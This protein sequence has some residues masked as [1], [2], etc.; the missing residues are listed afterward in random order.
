M[1][2][3]SWLSTPVRL[4]E[5]IKSAV[6]AAGGLSAPDPAASAG[7][8]SAPAASFVNPSSV[9]LQQALLSQ[10]FV[11]AAD[12]IAQL[13]LTL[14]ADRITALDTAFSSGSVL[15]QRFFRQP[16]NSWLAGKHPLNLSDARWMKSAHRSERRAIGSASLRGWSGSTPP[17][18]AL[19]PA[20]AVAPPLVPR[21]GAGEVGFPPSRY[22]QPQVQ[23]VLWNAR[24]IGGS[25]RRWNQVIDSSSSRPMVLRA[26]PLR[27]QPP[28][29]T[30]KRPSTR[31]V[32]CPHLQ[33]IYCYYDRP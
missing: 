22:S 33:S 15:Y 1:Q 4:V 13:D 14:R 23:L 12:T 29:T 5:V 31:V 11:D 32:V 19:P 7:S 17:A 3:S 30:R 25:A 18:V 9:A 21:S 24:S 28:T 2:I 10:T 8:A 27:S 26:A 6:R 20:A 16:G